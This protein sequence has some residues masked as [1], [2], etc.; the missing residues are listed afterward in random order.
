MTHF[1]LDSKKVHEIYGKNE[2]NMR[3]KKKKKLKKFLCGEIKQR[4]LTKKISIT[5]LIHR[6]L[7]SIHHEH[8]IDTK[9]YNQKMP[10]IKTRQKFW[11]LIELKGIQK[12]TI[13]V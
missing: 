12:C 10:Y 11:F 7:I 6:I 3:E 13:S 4:L 2:R 8:I 1:K 9:K 5:N